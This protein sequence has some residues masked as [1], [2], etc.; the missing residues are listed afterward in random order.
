[1]IHFFDGDDRDLQGED[2][3]EDEE[4][5]GGGDELGGEEM[6]GDDEEYEDEA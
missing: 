4:V 1:M 3:P 2:M 5:I 6:G